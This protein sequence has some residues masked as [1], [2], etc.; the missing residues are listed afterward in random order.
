[1]LKNVIL[2]AVAVSALTGVAHAADAVF[3]APEAPVA[4]SAAPAFSWGG[5]YGGVS[6]GYAWD[7][8]KFIGDDTETEK[9]DGARFSGFAGYNAEV[10][11]SII[12]GAEVDLGYS[13]SKK[14]FE[15]DTIKAGLNGAARAR[16]GYAFDQALIYAAGGYAVTKGKLSSTTV[17]GSD[18]LHGWTIGAGVDYA[19]TDKIFA[20]G[21]YRYNDFGKNTYTD[22]VGSWSLDAK[23]HVVNVGL[24]VKF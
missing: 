13:W 16:V 8:V 5:F 20:R 21:E 10:A 7:K 19:I 23:E 2:A 15:G 11:P 1:M 3:S 12:L 9:F 17:D 22:A 6:G 18:T 14:N 24:G 4:A